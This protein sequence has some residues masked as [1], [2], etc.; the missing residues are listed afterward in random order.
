MIAGAARMVAP[1][2]VAKVPVAPGKKEAAQPS[3]D[4]DRIR[5]KTIHL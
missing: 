1:F 4:F 2:F 3:E 5:D